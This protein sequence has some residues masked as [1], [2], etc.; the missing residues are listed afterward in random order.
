MIR[1]QVPSSGPER[2]PLAPS[3][4]HREDTQAQSILP[5]PQGGRSEQPETEQ[6]RK[7][8]QVRSY[9]AGGT[10]PPAAPSSFLRKAAPDTQPLRAA[11]AA[12]FLMC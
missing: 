6:P 7:E 1:A 4:G 10:E 5:L 12:L 9:Q 3:A 8:R 11:A 2:G